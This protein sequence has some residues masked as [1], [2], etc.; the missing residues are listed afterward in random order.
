MSETSVNNN[1]YKRLAKPLNRVREFEILRI[2]ATLPSLQSIK[3]A[4]AE[5]LKWVQNRSAERLPVQAWDM[6]DYEVNTGGRNSEAIR[7][8]QDDSD[9]WAIR[10]EDTDKFVAGRIWT[11]EIVIGSAIRGLNRFITIRQL[12]HTTELSPNVIPHAPGLLQQIGEVCGL[13]QAGIELSPTPEVIENIE[14]AENLID[15]VLSKERRMPILAISVAEGA[16]QPLV[17]VDA[18]SRAL[19]GVA[20]VVIIPAEV[21]WILT[22]RFGKARSV[23][24]GALR[25]YRPGFNEDSNPYDHKLILGSEI[26]DPTAA[27]NCE[28]WLRAALSKEA[29]Y[30][31]KIGSEI[32]AFSELRRIALKMRLETLSKSGASDTQIIANLHQQLEAYRIKAEESQQQNDYFSEEH[33]KA[34]ARANLLEGKLAA[35]NYRIKQLQEHLQEAGLAQDNIVI[36]PDNWDTFEDWCEKQFSDRLTLT[37]T[38]RRGCKNPEFDSPQLAA[39]CL[40]WLAESCRDRRIQGGGGSIREE[41]VIDGFRNAHCGS[42]A[43]EFNWQG[44]QLIADWH[45]KNGGNTRDPKKCLRIYYAWDAITQQI[46]I[47]DMPK[48]RRTGAT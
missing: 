13:S 34:E 1:E 18:L 17:K 4:R 10:A 24:G 41:V 28:E 8:T 14:D 46:I 25:I 26:Q 23:F 42:D 3:T 43:F 22:E 32:I 33:S 16:A 6:K 40:Q 15:A 30:T 47:A 7:I 21:T 27:R 35:A 19:Y 44:R 38:A 2:S 36:Y 9:I 12:V 29:I 31:N 48:H 37:P 20:H 11:T 5:V 45:V 39:Q